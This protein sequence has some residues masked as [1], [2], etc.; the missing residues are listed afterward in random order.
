MLVAAGILLSRLVGLVRQR[1][2]AH[3]LG[4]DVASAIWNT[5]T[6]IPNALQNLLG[7]GVLS[8]SF[9]PVYAGLRAQQRDDDAKRLAGAIFGVLS[10]VVA[11]LV[12]GGV[13]FA[14]LLVSLIAVTFTGETRDLTIALVRLIFPATGVLVLSA[15]C[16]GILNS[17]KRFFLSYAAPVAW[18][19]VIIGVVLAGR[20]RSDTELVAWA[21]WGYLGGSV[22]Q[23]VVQLP[24]VFSVLGRFSIRPSLTLPAVRQ[25]LRA[26]F[27]VMIAR[28]VVNL[29]A[30]VD[31]AYASL[32]GAR[33]VSTLGNAQTIALLPV[34]LFGMA[35][36]AAE[37]PEM[38][39]DA[40]KASDERAQALRERLSAGLGRLSF[41]VV[42][43]VVA[44]VLLGDLISG[45]LL[46]T[47][48]FKAADSRLV[49][50][51]LL[52]SGVAL[53]AQTS[54]RLFS[55]A[56][57][58]LKDTRTPL[59]YATL[60]VAL[61]IGLGYY[62]VHVLPGQLG[63]PAELGV[64]FITVTTGVTAWVEMLLLRRA[65]VKELGA[66]P[67]RL[68]LTLRVWLAAAIA[69]AT[70]LGLKLALTSHFGAREVNE[71]GGSFFAPPALPVL[72]TSLALLAIYAALYGGCGLLLGVEQ[73]R[74]LVRRVLRR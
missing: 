27:P 19:V 56:F 59:T 38:S 60:R 65:L 68:R 41:F 3:Y 62:A 73:A 55:S 8:A 28:G 63:L 33:A 21:A 57:Y 15:W 16:L 49:W 10:L 50:Y 1:L 44:F 18:N 47:G 20:H 11:A 6:R 13:L 70:T 9:I 14:P 69:G 26:F 17:H 31:L 35:I 37:L 67:S 22:A 72:P 66:L 2:L 30:L 43:S 71:W 5:A 58:A 53:S 64:V 7:E 42:P 51:V 29:S 24:T 34:S 36:S 45:V 61:G 23:F 39:A 40:V 32:V 12:V 46:E 54:G 4:N 74:A 48:R 52:G 25:V